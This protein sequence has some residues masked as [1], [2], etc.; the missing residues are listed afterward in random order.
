MQNAVM[1]ITYGS[2]CSYRLIPLCAARGMRMLRP[3]LGEIKET[4]ES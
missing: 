1:G 4:A 3:D 2:D